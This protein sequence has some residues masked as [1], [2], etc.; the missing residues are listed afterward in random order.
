MAQTR[1]QSM[2]QVASQA[3]ASALESRDAGTA[4]L[5]T[6][7][8]ELG[9]EGGSIYFLDLR[10]ARYRPFVHWPEACAGEMVHEVPAELLIEPTQQ[11]CDASVF[12]HSPGV[13]V[14]AMRGGICIGAICLQGLR[15]QSL[16]P[17]TSAEIM[18]VGNLLV[19]LYEREFASR[20]L[21]ALPEP[22]DFTQSEDDYFG[23]IGMLIANASSMQYAVV[24]ERRGRRLRC[25]TEWGYD[26]RRSSLD[27]DMDQDAD[28]PAVDAALDGRT[29]VVESVE[30]IEP[31]TTP[32]SRARSFVMLPVKVGRE[33]VGVLSLGT[34]TRYRYSPL[35][36]RGFEMIANSVGVSMTNFRSSRAASRRIADY[37]EAATALTAVSVAAQVR[38]EA[39][40]HIDNCNGYLAALSRMLASK[41]AVEPRLQG[42]S[43]EVAQIANALGRIKIATAPSMRVWEWV[44]VRDVWTQ[45]LFMVAGSL[46][47]RDIEVLLRGDPDVMVEVMPDQ[48]RSVFLQLLG[49]SIDAFDQAGRR[50]RRIR[51]VV[52]GPSKGCAD[53]LL[54]YF[55]NGSGVKPA[56]LRCPDGV[57][58]VPLKDLLFEAGATSKQEGSGLGL[59]LVRRILDDHCGSI[60]LREHRQGVAFAIRVPQQ[61]RMR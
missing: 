46:Q 5:R 45:A 26:C 50:A 61:R 31:E 7:V 16:G 59:W 27:L 34:G 41:P 60:E 42:I 52:S 47:R 22:I 4:V 17:T 51:L 14:L 55:D 15:A 53:V 2:L 49:N 28:H 21:G 24:R 44:S 3:I 35:E 36:M 12:S 48:I 40:Q 1:H 9:A 13:A 57:E 32:T 38:H 37:T 29:V 43:Q 6:C 54:E 30:E 23:D 19:S 39:M 58:S 25:V 8:R 11:T 20:L 18:A 56:H 10:T 33:I